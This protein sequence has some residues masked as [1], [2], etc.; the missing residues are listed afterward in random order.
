[1]HILRVLYVQCSFE[2][3][4]SPVFFCECFLGPL[5]ACTSLTRC[6]L[7]QAHDLWIVESN[8]KALNGSHIQR[9]DELLLGAP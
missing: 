3:L 1:M 6:E 2:F 9:L 5:N 4:T 7:F 8:V